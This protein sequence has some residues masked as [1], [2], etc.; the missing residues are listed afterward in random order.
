MP[1]TEAAWKKILKSAWKPDYSIVIV[2]IYL[3]QIVK[4]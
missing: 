4:F 1:L 3:K 2:M